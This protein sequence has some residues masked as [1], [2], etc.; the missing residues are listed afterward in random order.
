MLKPGAT[1]RMWKP[2]G[3][4]S[5]YQSPTTH[6]YGQRR[7]T[8]GL[9]TCRLLRIKNCCVPCGGATAGF[10]PRDQFFSGSVGLRASSG[11]A[12]G[13]HSL[14]RATNPVGSVRLHHKT[15]GKCTAK[16]P[17]T[18]LNFQ[19]QL[20]MILLRNSAIFTYV[21]YFTTLPAF[22]ILPPSPFISPF[23]RTWYDISR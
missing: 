5:S 19:L 1:V 14:P 6:A 7:L 9:N 13:L 10:S 18:L 22:A 21:R 3:S 12:R 15:K 23:I 17:T 20:R 16:R 11:V 2:L 8:T 4:Y